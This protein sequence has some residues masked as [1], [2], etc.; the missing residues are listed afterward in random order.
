[1]SLSLF[2]NNYEEAIQV[3]KDTDAGYE[4]NDVNPYDLDD[5]LDF[6][7]VPGSSMPESRASRIDQ[8][9]DLVQ[10]GLLQPDQFW[11]WT[12][13]DLSQ[14]IIKEIAQRNK[15]IQ[16]E[17]ARLQEIINTSEDKQEIEDAIIQL[18]EMTGVGQQQQI[19]E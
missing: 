4:F 17:V 9:L 19:Q 1:M 2:K 8:A 18:R 11:M 14:D 6:K 16:E 7:Y 13:R 5:D 12:Q 3:R 15:A 10:M